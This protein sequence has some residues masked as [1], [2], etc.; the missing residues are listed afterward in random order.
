MSV[1]KTKLTVSNIN[2]DRQ[3]KK[4][5]KVVSHDTGKKIPYKLSIKRKKTG[6]DK[7]NKYY[8][9]SLTITYTSSAGSKSVTK[10]VKASV[11]K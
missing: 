11:P 8:K 9:V 5:I 2:N 10:T 1:D 4:L 7:S 6:S 3:F